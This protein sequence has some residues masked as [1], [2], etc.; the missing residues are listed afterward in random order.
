MACIFFTIIHLFQDEQ[1]RIK[2][3]RLLI[4]TFQI[5]NFILFCHIALDS[6]SRHKEKSKKPETIR[7]QTRLW[8]C[9]PEM[10]DAAF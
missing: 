8:S 4:L 7:C 5:K 3:N 2:V 10:C 9:L 1:K 6:Q